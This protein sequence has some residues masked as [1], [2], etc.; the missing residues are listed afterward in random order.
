MNY[1]EHN[2]WL[3]D[4]RRFSNVSPICIATRAVRAR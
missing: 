4:T 2:R 1:L 3:D